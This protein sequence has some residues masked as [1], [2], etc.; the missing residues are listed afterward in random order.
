MSDASMFKEIV[1]FITPHVAQ[2]NE[3]TAL[4]LN[5]FHN[6]PKLLNQ[7][8]YEGSAATFV[9]SVVQRLRVY[10]TTTDGHQALWQLLLTLKNQVGLDGERAIDRFRDWAN[11][12]APAASEASP[13]PESPKTAF[14][15]LKRQQLQAMLQLKLEQYK[16]VS[17]E[18]ITNMNPGDVAKLR[19]MLERFEAEIDDLDQ[20]LSKLR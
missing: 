11:A 14:K 17:D 4:M 20:Q 6:E 7:I 9:P 15:E 18:I 5:A 1:D 19:I 2:Q 3:R 16:A 13:A 8:T 12:G 10:G